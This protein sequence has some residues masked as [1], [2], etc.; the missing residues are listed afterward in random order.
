M[1]WG[2][3]MIKAHLGAKRKRGVEESLKGKRKQVPVNQSLALEIANLVRQKLRR[4]QI[5]LMMY[6]TQNTNLMQQEQ[7][8]GQKKY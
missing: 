8:K 4:T 2:P 7:R 3:V 1:I 5:I 6:I